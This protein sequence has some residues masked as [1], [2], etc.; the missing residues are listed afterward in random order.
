VISKIK[1]LFRVLQQ[2]N[3]LAMLSN[4]IAVIVV[5]VSLRWTSPLVVGIALSVYVIAILLLHVFDQLSD[6]SWWGRW[7]VTGYMAVSIIG[8]ALGLNTGA[9][10]ISG[11]FLALSFALSSCTTA[12]AR[13]LDLA[14]E[15]IPGVGRTY[16][17][18]FI[19]YL[20][21][22]F[23]IGLLCLAWAGFPVVNVISIVASSII[24]AMTLGNGCIGVIRFYK[25]GRIEKQVA[26][27]LSEMNP[28]F[29]FFFGTDASQL[30]QVKMWLPLLDK[31]GL[32]YFILTRNRETFFELEN[33]TKNPV[34]Y[35]RRFEDVEKVF[36][37]S[38]K[39]FLYVNTALNNMQ[40]VRF[41]QF[42]HIMLNH[43]DSDK[44]ASFA[45]TM[46]MYDRNFVAGQAAIDRF[47]DHGVEVYRPQFEIVGRPQLDEVTVADQEHKA[48][49]HKP[50]VLYAP[51]W[52]GW[53]SD[54]QY[55]S[56]FEGERLIQILLD[57]GYRVIFRSH[58]MTDKNPKLAAIS[59]RVQKLLEENNAAGGANVYGE[60]AESTMSIFE[61]FNESDMLITDVS[62]V[63]SDYLYSLKPIVMMNVSSTP[64]DFETEFPLAKASYVVDILGGSIEELNGALESIDNGD[65]MKPIR[66]DMK[67]YY[68]SE[69]PSGEPYENLFLNTLR[70]YV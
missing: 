15:H 32:P 35:A 23:P 57:R 62:S 65:P 59:A 18:S 34:V 51:T 33:M 21:V 42:K 40:M 24:L 4:V 36:V 54:S 49:D 7:D 30:Y 68:L 37:P 39:T 2:V 10:T 43:G 14:G 29:A 22:A 13:R 5:I 52:S 6:A 66:T 61:C 58:P 60:Q 20:S 67:R 70:K 53:V 19:S 26:G 27:A 17:Y 16:H 50:T 64:E 41:P 69:A 3:G 44:V 45:P 56:L 47:T 12:L 8:I 38:L 46:R 55:S 1:W 25:R 9:Y 11:I 48:A 31:L 63:P 28:S